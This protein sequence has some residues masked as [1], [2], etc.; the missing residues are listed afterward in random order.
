MHR[1]VF[2]EIQS[3]KKYMDGTKEFMEGSIPQAIL[4]YFKDFYKVEDYLN[5]FPEQ[6]I[7]KK[8]KTST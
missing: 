5:D 3:V 7:L 1:S 4:D 8:W 2:F 6:E